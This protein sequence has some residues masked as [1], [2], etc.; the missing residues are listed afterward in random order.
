MQ[1]TSNSRWFAKTQTRAAAQTAVGSVS[2]VRSKQQFGMIPLK[3]FF[4][5]F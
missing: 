2:T 1:N 3:G 5:V 4:Q